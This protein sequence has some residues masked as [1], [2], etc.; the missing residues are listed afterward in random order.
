[1]SCDLS[2]PTIS[3]AYEAVVNDQGANWLLLGYR[4]SEDSVFLY[5]TGEG[6]LE[7]LKS[8]LS[9]EVLYGYLKFEDRFV[10]ITYISDEISGMR[11]ARAFVHGKQIVTV[12]NKYDVYLTA[13]NLVDLTDGNIRA[14]F[15][16]KSTEP[17]TQS[18]IEDTATTLEPK[19]PAPEEMSNEHSLAA[20]E[21][22]EEMPGAAVEPIA[23]PELQAPSAPIDKEEVRENVPAADETPPYV[24]LEE[25]PPVKEPIE[26]EPER[27]S[28]TSLQSTQAEE[29]LKA[30]IKKREALMSQVI[31]CES[32]GNVGKSLM[33]D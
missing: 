9:N 5:A 15:R 10:F 4:D 3:P 26:G 18:P 21:V 28:P 1:M 22:P 29:I 2:D 19:E 16:P 25:T 27:K 33:L 24:E 12:F 23:A 31:D 17:K 8:H 13:S 32:A 30:E 20:V 6:G 11:R 7:E 14:H